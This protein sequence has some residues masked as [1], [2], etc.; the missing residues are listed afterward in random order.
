MAHRSGALHKD[1][2]SGREGQVEA[3]LGKI[4]PTDYQIRGL[5]QPRSDHPEYAKAAEVVAAAEAT[6]A[7]DPFAED[8][9]AI[10]NRAT[11]LDAAKVALTAADNRRKPL[12]AAAGAMHAT[13]HKELTA[14]VAKLR[15]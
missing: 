7:A 8:A 10:A 11:K 6:T 3:E 15:P 4:A 5:Q 2:R 12:R 1:A 14:A 13:L 9:A